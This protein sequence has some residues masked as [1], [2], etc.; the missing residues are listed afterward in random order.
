MVMV[1]WH[2]AATSGAL[3]PHGCCI[4]WLGGGHR[5]FF[6]QDGTVDRVCE[7]RLGF[8][9]REPVYNDAR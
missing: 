9:A 3:V 8:E 4:P 2:A 6:V 7:R 1:R 5:V